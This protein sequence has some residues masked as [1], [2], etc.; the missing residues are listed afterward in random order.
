[1]SAMSSKP[2]GRRVPQDFEH[3][4]KYPLRALTAEAQPTHV[5]MAIGVNWYT[6]FDD[7]VKVGDRWWIGRGNLGSIRGGH[8]V[9][10]KPSDRTD[11]TSWWDFYNQINEG[12]CVGEGG[13]T[14]DAA[15]ASARAGRAGLRGDKGDPHHEPPMGCRWGSARHA[16]SAGETGRRGHEKGTPQRSRR[17]GVKVCLRRRHAVTCVPRARRAKHRLSGSCP[18]SA[19]AS[20]RTGVSRRE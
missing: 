13:D 20:A 18:A 16:G 4:D 9:C 11:P 5:P 17:A 12:K 6:N 1:M 10:I 3:V 2:L 8:C 7:P 14:L 19:P 15:G